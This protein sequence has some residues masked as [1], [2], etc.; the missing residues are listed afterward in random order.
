M[1]KKLLAP[2][3]L[4]LALAGCIS[5]STYHP[6]NGTD[7]YQQIQMN[8]TLWEIRYTGNQATQQPQVH[9]MMLYRAAEIARN[10]GFRFFRVLSQNT[11]D[12]RNVFV[13]PG[14]SSTYTVKKHHH[15]RRVTEYNPPTRSVTNSY[16]TIIRV[17]LQH[18]GGGS[19]VYNARTLKS[20][21]GPQITWPKPNS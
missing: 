16:T 11:Q 1:S 18:R 5:P 13:Q 9:N 20:S 14:Y 15:K 3:A 21:L 8:R 12:H 2:I 4:S 7:G 10:H 19:R 6:Y 17:R